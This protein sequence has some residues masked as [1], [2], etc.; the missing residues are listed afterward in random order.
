MNDRSGLSLPSFEMHAAAGS[1]RD[2]ELWHWAV[3]PLFDLDALSRRDRGDFAMK[4]RGF[5]YSD[6]PI[7]T[8]ASSGSRFERS[9]R[10]IARAGLE[11]IIVQVYAE[12]GYRFTAGGEERVAETGDIVAFDLT[13]PCTVRTSDAFRQMSIIVP[14]QLLVP[15]AS[16][17]DNMHGIVLRKETPLNSLLVAHMHALM[18]EGER[19]DIVAGAAMVRATAALVAACFGSSTETREHAAATLSSAL[20]R[21]IRHG[22]DQNLADPTLGPD[23]LTRRFNLSRASLYRLFE[24]LG[25]VRAYIQMRRLMRIHQAISDPALFHQP[26]GTLAA[27]WGF[28]DKTVFSRAYKT[29]YGVTPS[30]ARARARTRF[31][32]EGQEAVR[33]LGSFWEVNRWLCGLE[34]LSPKITEE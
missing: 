4:S 29:L 8:F 11:N 34:T 7:S 26:I 10:V 20:L 21:R 32:E 15:L 31:R 30:D 12:G 22:I 6:M 24:P 33:P 27:R 28:P 2:F 23:M 9:N 17:V 14:R 1:E 18:A 19:V 13:R 3:S 16:N 5:Y 25:G